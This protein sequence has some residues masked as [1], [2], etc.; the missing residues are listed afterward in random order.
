[1]AVEPAR[2]ITG[3]VTYAGTG[4]PAPHA[5]V[6]I[7]IS[8]DDGSSA[9]AD[10]VETD[11][12]GRFRINPGAARRYFLLAFPPERKPYL[13]VQKILEWPKGAIE[14]SLDLVLPR[15]VLVRGRVT[16]VGSG[17]PVAGARVGY[18]SN[19]D[20][21]LETGAW[22]SRAMTAVDG[23]FEFGV[24]P[25]P[26]YVTVL[27]SDEDFVL[28][29]ISQRMALTGQPG[30]HRLYVHGFHRLDLKPGSASQDVAITLRPS[31]AIYGRVVAPDGRPVRDATVISRVILQPTWISFLFW[32]AAYR[33]SVRDGC[34]AVHGLAEDA[35]I[36]VYFFDAR[37]ELGVTAYLSSKLALD[38]PVTVRL[39]RCGQARARLVDSAGKP[40][41]RS[42]D[43]YGSHMT[44]MV[45]TPGPH[46]MSL[47]KVDQDRL[48]A[49][50]DFLARFDPIHYQKGLVSD[51]EGQLILPALIPG[52]TYRIY[53]NT[54][55]N[56]DNP[57]LRKEFTVKPGERLDLGDILIEKPKM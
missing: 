46:R 24:M 36:P 1:M 35:E 39:Q 14:H 5:V 34:F 41:P 27:G 47:N 4:Q 12:Q 16:E 8:R 28:R 30:G 40:V 37:H 13:N 21:D 23:S 19:P 43:T 3:R 56:G 32:T 18:I 33:D 48:A 42:R 55:T 31:T 20:R 57:Q 53:D 11:G 54:M 51:N 44:M 45:V 9:W 29:E 10:D 7:S 52:A 2:I 22:N 17:K 50:Q 6:D 38:G 26:G 15:G 49:D 25:G